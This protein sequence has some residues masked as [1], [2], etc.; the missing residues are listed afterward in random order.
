MPEH[1]VIQNEL[2]AVCSRLESVARSLSLQTEADAC[3]SVLLA[4][5]SIHLA[6]DWLDESYRISTNHGGNYKNARHCFSLSL[7]PK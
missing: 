4:M 6:K 7:L 1:L 2:S 3:S 5:D